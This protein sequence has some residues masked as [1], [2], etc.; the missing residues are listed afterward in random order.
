MAG[1]SKAKGCLDLA[2]GAE[3]V[4]GNWELEIDCYIDEASFR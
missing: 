3:L 1:K 2:D 4:L